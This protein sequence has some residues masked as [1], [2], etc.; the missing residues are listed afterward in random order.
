MN[1][2]LYMPEKWRS[3]D[4]GYTKKGAKNAAVPEELFHKTKNQMFLEMIVGA[5]NSGN[6]KKRCV[7]VDGVFGR[8]HKFLDSLPK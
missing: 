2:R 3:D 4:D 1:A 5:V 8:D 6:F 7:G